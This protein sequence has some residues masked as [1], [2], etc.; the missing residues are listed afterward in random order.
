MRTGSKLL[1]RPPPWSMLTTGVPATT[2][3][4]LTVPPNGAVTAC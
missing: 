4:K 1:T 3:E 2:P